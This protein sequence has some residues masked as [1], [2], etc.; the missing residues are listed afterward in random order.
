MSKDSAMLMDASAPGRG[1][2]ESLFHEDSSSSMDFEGGDRV[3]GVTTLVR[4]Q[5]KIKYALYKHYCL[6][7]IDYLFQ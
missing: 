6:P 7:W 5:T 1:S 2:Q 3:S 4:T